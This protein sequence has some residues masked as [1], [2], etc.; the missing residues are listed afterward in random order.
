[1]T[2]PFSFHGRIGRVQYLLWSAAA[3]FSQHLAV[4]IACR[5]VRVQPDMDVVFW[6]VPLRTLVTQVHASDAVLIGGMAFFL[7][8]AW[9]LAVLAFRRAADADVSE[10]IAVGAMAPLVQVPVILGLAVM[11][12]RPSEAPAPSRAPAK[13]YAAAA[14]GVSV[15]IGL[16]LAAVAISTLGF[17]TYGYGLFMVSPFV[18]GAATG[19]VANRKGDIGGG[20][21]SSLVMV[22]LALGGIALILTSLEGLICIVLAAPLAAGVAWVGGMAGRAIALANRRPPRQMAPAVAALPVIFALEALFAPTTAFDTVQSITIDAPA[23][24]VWRSVLH[25]DRIEGPLGLPQRFGVA[26]PVRGEVIGQ[27]V[28]AVRHGE[29]STGTA[30]ERVTEWQENRR[31][32]FAVESD[33]PAMREISPYQHVHAPH[34]IGYFT[35]RTTSFELSPRDGGATELTLRSA[36]MVRLDPLLYW[37]PFARWAVAENNARVLAHVKRQSERSARAAR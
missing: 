14:L 21:T 23:A 7:L 10:G 17:G 34:V 5:Q 31:L 3:F 2:S 32:A 11:P 37:M 12:S 6:L 15:G 13:N 25:M 19:Y 4:L 16:T 18:I 28:G 20:A 22:A 36:H 1:M 27:G 33:I 35:T 26:Y 9:V 29:F 8:V 24:A 30:I